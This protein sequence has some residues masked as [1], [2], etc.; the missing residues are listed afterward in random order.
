LVSLTID[1]REV[2]VEE[3][4]TIL[5]AAEA[6]SIYIPTFCYHK[7]L[8]PFGACRMCVVEV[9]QMK[10][11][12]IP[13]CSTPAT[14]GMVVRTN[15]PEIREARKTLLELLLIHHPLD[16]PVCDK[17]GDCKL[18]DLAYEYEVTENRFQD[19]KF[20]YPVDYY[21]PLI[22]R[23]TNR[24]VLCGMCT[25]VCDEVVGVAA[26]SFVNRGFSTVIGTNFESVLNCEFC[27][28]CVNICPVGALTDKLFKYKARTWELKKVNTICS[29][30]STGCTLTLGVKGNKIYRVIGDDTIGVNKGSLCAKGRFGYQYITSPERMNSPLVKNEDGELIRATWE[31]A[32]ERVAR[33]FKEVRERHGADSIGGICSDRLTN[34]EVYLFQKFM[35]AA[36]GTNSI[37][38]AGGFSYSGLLNGLSNS[39]GYA[40]NDITLDDVRNA[41]VIFVLR[42]NLS[43]THPVIGY[44][45][46]MAVKMDESKLVVASNR[47]IKLNRLAT[48]S[49][50]HKPNTE[51][52]LLNEMVR[53]IISRNLYDHA[54][55][56]SSTEGFDELKTQVARYSEDYVEKITG[57]EKDK[58]R[59]AARL[60]SQGKRVCILIS[61]GLGTLSDD[62]KLAQAVANLALLTGMVG[63]EGSG[64]G[65]LGEKCN[66]QGALDMGALP[67]LLPG[68]QEVSD[69]KVRGTFEEVWGISIPSQVGQGA[70]EMLLSAEK[71]NIKGLY[72]VGENPVVTYPDSAQTKKALGALDF[73]VVQDLFLTP[74][75]RCADVVLPVASFAEKRGTYTNFERR[76]Q[77]LQCGLNKLEGVKTD[78]EIFTELSLK[79]GYEMKVSTSEGVMQE[80][81]GLVPLYAEIKYPLL[82]EEGVQWSLPSDKKKVSLY[83]RGSPL[84]KY[85]FIPVVG[86]EMAQEP[87]EEYPLLL[88]TGSILFHSGSLSTKSPQLNQVGSGG[89]VEISPE[90]ASKYQLQDGQAIL[91]RSKEGEINAQVKISKKQ[92]KGTVFIP[93]HF[94][95]Q[96]VSLLTSKNLHP[97][98]VELK[99][100]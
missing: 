51:I 41:D 50:T 13:S 59:E 79:M 53:T 91:V 52:T 14:N 27:G 98:F 85:R 77:R 72:I 11:R 8:M 25:R 21:S 7:R 6:A 45:V 75:A 67:H 74:T 56:S 19:K 18:Q 35:R 86:D 44:Q 38:H 49:L 100:A 97:T 42:S 80:I 60:L 47:T 22:E 20:D 9:E 90:D 69:E 16:C 95:S 73:L 4:A 89:W 93:Y 26:V 23:N 61:S 76:V 88:L 28:E 40:A 83:S 92:V 1:E 33:G 48:L 24:C 29:Y 65:F 2:E 58:I 36:I 46:N 82:S 34:E 5:E 54:F 71:G 39:L 99:K 94:E 84:G 31:E 78:L 43:E 17:G 55:V 62:E 66:S 3:G 10:G 70:L 96:S 64:I 57:V 37:D 81:N 12:L 30:C 63:R 68:Y 87:D 32:L 15:T